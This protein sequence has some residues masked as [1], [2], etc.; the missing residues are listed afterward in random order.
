MAAE[1]FAQTRNLLAG[2]GKKAFFYLQPLKSVD[3]Q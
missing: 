2:F 1:M 3:F